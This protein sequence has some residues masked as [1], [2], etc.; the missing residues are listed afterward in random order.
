MITFKQFLAEAGA[1]KTKIDAAEAVRLI[2]A[3]C[4][5]ALANKEPLY[6]GMRGTDSDGFILHGEA[7]KRHSANT[8]NYYT[9]ILDHFLPA[10]GFPKRSESIILA[11]NSGTASGFGEEVY[12]IFPYDGVKIGICYGSDLWFSPS[13]K[14]GNS[15]RKNQINDWNETWEYHDLPS[16]SYED[17]VRA[18]KER[19]GTGY[20]KKSKWYSSLAEIFGT[21]SNV[22]PALKEAYS[23]DTLKMELATSKTIDNYENKS[24]ELWISGKCVAI[25]LSEWRK[26]QAGNDDHDNETPP[27]DEDY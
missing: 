27:D 26:M 11:N 13:F 14:I 21:A 22:E 16:T 4:R 24:H 20:D 7:S 25:R 3:H 12:A 10:D 8:S 6:R 17:F 5:D 15:D 9:I 19:I 23:S 2:N 18:I 1:H